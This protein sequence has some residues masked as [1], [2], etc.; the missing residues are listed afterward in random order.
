MSLNINP[1]KLKIS[2]KEIP[3]A[4]ISNVFMT[5]SNDEHEVA[6]G[7]HYNMASGHSTSAFIITL[8]LK[9]IT[10]IKRIKVF[11]RV[12]CCQERM[13]GFSVFIKRLRSEGEVNCGELVDQYIEYVIECDGTGYKVELR[14]EGEVGH[15][16]L[17]EIEIYGG[18]C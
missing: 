11:N 7:N 9:H 18:N 14:K 15:V 13:V 3:Q 4:E 1:K 6:D 8:N 5:N 10:N 2:E 16:N 17:A 12:D